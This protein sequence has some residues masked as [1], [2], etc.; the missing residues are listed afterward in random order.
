MTAEKLAARI[1]D[2]RLSMNL[3]QFDFAA[4]C[5]LNPGNISILEAGKSTN[6]TFGTLSKIADGLQIHVSELLAEKEPN[7]PEKDPWINKVT[8]CM[9]PLSDIERK[10]VF[11]LV[12]SAVMLREGK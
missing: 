3:S 2:I 4:M 12:R 11:E 6:M 8:T 9:K 1:K 7:I 5:G 10:R